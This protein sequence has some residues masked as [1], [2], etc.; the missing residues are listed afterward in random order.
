[1]VSFF[2]G[3]WSLA[4]ER[5]FL[6]FCIALIMLAAVSSICSLVFRMWNR[7]MRS[8]N[9]AQQGWPTNPLMDA[10]GDIIHPR[11]TDEEFLDLVERNRR[12]MAEHLINGR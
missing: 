11:I 5:P 10:D 7:L 6:A 2:T 3:F 12:N 1:M 9:I 4:I 8:R